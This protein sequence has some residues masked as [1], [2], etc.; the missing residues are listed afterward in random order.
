MQKS[1]TAV[2]AQMNYQRRKLE[3]SEIAIRR[4]RYAMV[5]REGHF[6]NFAP[7]KSHFSTTI[8]TPASTTTSPTNSSRSEAAKTLQEMSE[9]MQVILTNLEIQINEADSKRKKLQIRNF[10]LTRQ[11]SNQENLMYNLTKEKEILVEK[12]A[13]LEKKFEKA[14]QDNALLSSHN[15]ERRGQTAILENKNKALN[16]SIATRF[17]QNQLL[18]NE[19][20]IMQNQI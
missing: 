13:E 12:F 11:I 16:K 5:R 8:L 20:V 4:M 14:L 3:A 19:R 2:Q 7:R 6:Q 9:E 10:N 15:R 1:L 18:Q 17:S